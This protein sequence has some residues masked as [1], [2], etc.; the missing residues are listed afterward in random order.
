[1]GPLDPSTRT[2]AVLDSTPSSKRIRGTTVASLHPRL[3]GD[4][5]RASHL[6]VL[7]CRVVRAVE[8]TQE[9]ITA[10]FEQGFVSKHRVA[11]VLHAT[12]VAIAT[13]HEPAVLGAEV[14]RAP[15]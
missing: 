15:L 4:R 9:P 11:L 1:M 3:G 12:L 2:I 13:E 8:P 10:S 14:T 6:R 7:E 5:L